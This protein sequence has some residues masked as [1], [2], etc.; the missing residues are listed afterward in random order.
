ML[1]TMMF[2]L[3][4][5]AH[6]L[7]QAAAPAQAAPAGQQG[8]GQGLA[9]APGGQAGQR[10]GQ[11]G[12]QATPAVVLPTPRWPDGKVRLGA[13]PG[14]KGLWNGGGSTTSP[15]APYQPWARAMRD[16]RRANEFEPHTRCK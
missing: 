11:R 4:F 2:A 8:V 10:G 7:G 16:Y 12:A 15:D 13:P 9:P 3:S 6:A 1:L 14:E 5:A